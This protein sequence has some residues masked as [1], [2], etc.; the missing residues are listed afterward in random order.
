M[1]GTVRQRLVAR[2]PESVR[3]PLTPGAMHLHMLLVD[4]VWVRLFFANRHRLGDNVWRSAQPL[5]HHI[6][7][8][9]RQG[10]RTILNLRGKTRTSTWALERATCTSE[11]IT[12]VDLAMKSRAAPTRETIRAVREVLLGAER[13]LVIHCKSG[14]DRA[15]LVSA[16][17]LHLVEGVPMMEARRQLSL[18]YGHVRQG[19]TGILDAVIERYIADDA[20]EPMPFMKWV[21]TVYDPLV[22]E[23]SFKG[24]RW[25][26]RLINRILR[27]E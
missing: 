11:G 13:P 19:D 5:P 21:E 17:Y 7:R 22:I 26:N 4:H 2:L 23:Q 15:G 18:R 16:L 1:L 6:R 9:R 20:R 25:A 12:L 14:A 24:G 8:M 10:V 27:R 3:R